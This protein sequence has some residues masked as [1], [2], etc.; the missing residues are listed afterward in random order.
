MGARKIRDIE[1]YLL[2]GTNRKTTDIVIERDGTICV[3]PPLNKTAEEVD[4]IVEDKR[5][6]IYKNLAEWKE[7]N[8]TAISR[9]LVNGESYYYLG[10]NYRLRLV[11]DQKEPLVLKGGR[12]LLNIKNIGKDPQSSS[13]K[14][15]VEFY[16]KKGSKR[17]EERVEYFSSKVGVKAGIISIKDL[18]YRWALC[19]SMGNLKFHWKCMMAPLSVI[20]YIIVHE[21]C[22]I[23]H[24]DHSL[25]F[26]N[27]VDKVLP[28]Y[29][30]RKEWLRINGASLDI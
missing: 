2:E 19:S 8:A 18:G 9:E 27:E 4:V 3:R 1:Y 23:H 22:H 28:D 12:F 25:K 7:L 26:W 21:L 13:Q 30:K 17:I 10:R 5:M 20:D 16:M 29:A 6:W 24:K 14:A 11:L 15:F